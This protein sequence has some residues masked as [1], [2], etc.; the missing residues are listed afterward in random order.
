MST[1]EVIVVAREKAKPVAPGANRPPAALLSFKESG[2]A[3][4]GFV[5]SFDASRTTDPDGSVQELS[6]R[7]DWESDGTF[8]T[9]WIKAATVQHEFKKAGK[10]QVRV[11]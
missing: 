2:D 11:K 8:D 4:T 9:E 10:H 1:S 6:F 5:Y 3:Q 7:W